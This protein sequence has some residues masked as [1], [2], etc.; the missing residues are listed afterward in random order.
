MVTR[1]RV[2]RFHPNLEAGPPF[3]ITGADRIPRAVFVGQ[4]SADG[5][6]G[7]CSLL[8]AL[9]VAGAL[10]PSSIRRIHD[11]TYGRLFRLREL[12]TPQMFSGMDVEDMEAALKLFSGLIDFRSFEGRHAATLRFSLGH[13]EEGCC[14]L[15]AIQQRGASHGHWVLATGTEGIQ[16]QSGRYRPES[17]LLLDPEEDPTALVPFNSRLS[18]QRNSCESRTMRYAPRIRGPQIVTLTA[19]IAVWKRTRPR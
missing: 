2:F 5:A 18:L 6:C 1:H 7:F 4:G 11:R 13:L 8:M 15:V 14:V 10:S 17:I 16:T 19:A 9:T 3:R 12:V